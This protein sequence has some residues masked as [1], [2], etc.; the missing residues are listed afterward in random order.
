M[1]PQIA[2]CYYPTSIAFVDDSRKFLSAIELSMASKFNCITFSDPI[3]ALNHANNLNNVNWNSHG[4]NDAAYCS[5]S[6]Q[7]IKNTLNLSINKL[8]D[9]GRYNEISVVVVDYDMP[10]MNGIEFCRNLKNPNTKRILLTGQ[11]STEEAVQA[12]NENVINYYI[13][14]GDVNLQEHLTRAITNLQ[15]RYFLDISSYIKIRAI[16]NKQS[17]FNDAELSKYLAKIIEAHEIKEY[18]F[19]T[20]PPHYKLH[21]KSGET[22]ILLVYSRSDL[23][24]QIRTI[25]EEAGPTWLLDCLKSGN[26]VP[27]FHSSDGFYDQ[28]SFD[29]KST[30]YLAD[31]IK[32]ND[33]Y[34]CAHITDKSQAFDPA[35]FPDSSVLH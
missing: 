16:E 7:F 2:L 25:K 11:A 14:K 28:E 15:Y 3:R 24:E 13:N 18:Y 34:F 5:D 35:F 1:K 31:V 29:D 12:F 33:T 19:L 22:S 10:D 26:Y 27:Y 30:V 21:S 9:T 23:N 6:E 20:N 32:G 17:L 4:K 8:N